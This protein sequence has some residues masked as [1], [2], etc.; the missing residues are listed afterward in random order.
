ML[1]EPQCKASI[2]TS[3]DIRIEVCPSLFPLLVKFFF[4][5]VLQEKVSIATFVSYHPKFFFAQRFN[6]TQCL[7][8]TAKPHVI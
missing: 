4:A 7:L 3:G 5:G 1:V 8:R 6:N 2:T